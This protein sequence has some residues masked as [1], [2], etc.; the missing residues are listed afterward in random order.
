MKIVCFLN[1]DIHCKTALELISPYLKDHQ[2]KFVVSQKVGKDRVLPK[3]VAVMRELEKY[4]IINDATYYSDINSNE[5]FEDLKKFAP[6]LM[7]SIRYGQ[8]FKRP[9]LIS[10]PR[11]GIINLHSGMLPKYRGIM[12]SFWAVLHGE[13][14]IGMTLHYIVDSTIDTGPII[15]S[16]KQEVDRDLPMSVNVNSLYFR[17]CEMVI[18]AMKKIFAGQKINTIDQKTLGESRYFSYP[19]EEEVKKFLEIMTLF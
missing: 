1:N 19:K 11:F 18:N 8:I 6:D 17:G 5:A 2:V 16:F 7:L 15:D 9:E 4:K 3:A 10:L 14:N 12:A 13:E